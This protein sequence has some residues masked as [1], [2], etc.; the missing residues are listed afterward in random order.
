MKVKLP[1]LGEDDEVDIVR[2]GS[3]LLS[4]PLTPQM[5]RHSGRNA[6]FV[7]LAKKAKAQAKQAKFALYCA[8]EDLERELRKGWTRDMKGIKFGET[9]LKTFVNSDEKI[10]ALHRIYRKRCDEADLLQGFVDIM[11]ER[12]DLLQSIG[13]LQRADTGELRTSVDAYNE[14]LKRINKKLKLKLEKVLKKHGSA[15]S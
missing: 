4:M 9:A 8:Q 15:Q 12:K 5:A 3:I 7:T 14:K 2:E 11:K 1:K 6:W 13:A 10:R